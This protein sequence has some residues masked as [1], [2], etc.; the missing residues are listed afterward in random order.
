MKWN[1]FP[2]IAFG[3]LIIG[4][5]LAIKHYQKL[6]KNR[7]DKKI[8]LVSIVILFAIASVVGLGAL[9]VSFYTFGNTTQQL[10]SYGLIHPSQ[11][12]TPLSQ[13][14]Q[15][16]FP[17]ILALV[18]IGA[19]LLYW[20]VAPLIQN[21]V[22]T[23]RTF[24]EN[25][26]RFKL[27]F[28]LPTMGIALVSLDGYWMK[29][30]PALCNILGYSE[31]ELLQMDFQALTHPE[32]VKINLANRKELLEGKLSHFEM[33]ER[34]Y[35]KNE[36][37]IWVKVNV[38]LMR[39]LSGEPLYFVTQLQ[40]INKQKEAEQ[41]LA[42]Q[43]FFDKLTGLANR[44]QLEHLFGHILGTARRHSKKFAVLFLDLDKFKEV[45]DTLGHHAGDQ[46]LI[47]MA[48]RL[49]SSVRIN[50][51]VSRWGGDEFILMITDIE[52]ET[53][54][55]ITAEKIKNT[56]LHPVRIS[57]HELYLTA[58]VGISIYPTDGF[59]Y[60]ILIKN[61]DAALYRAKENGRNNYQFYSYKASENL[62]EKIEFENALQQA[63][64]K[65]EFQLH[66]QPKLDLTSNDVIGFESLL[67]WQSE[68]Y[69]IVPPKRILSLA[70]ETGLIIPLSHW[71]LKAVCLQAKKWHDAG[72]QGL[73]VSL[74]ISAQQFKQSDFIYN[75]S[76][77][78]N[79]TGL[80]SHC[81]ELEISESLAMQDP[82]YTL[83]IFSALKGLG[84]QIT[85]DN[86][87]TGYSSF[88]YLHQFAVDRIK[89]DKSI[90]QSIAENNC[91]TSLVMTMISLSKN[92][93]V[94]I[95]AQ[96][97]ETKHQYVFL[98]KHHC[99]EAQGFYFSQPLAIKKAD[100]FLEQLKIVETI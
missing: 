39:N 68:K 5:S 81:L 91:D 56:L 25:E 84:V 38:S 18:V 36:G 77:T 33:E 3:M 69:G 40:D 61:A 44:N 100:E 4:M 35:K 65:N 59:N 98:R 95:L 21:I 74:N 9:A 48:D 26:T 88:S 67:R 14:L 94:K 60:E 63:L 20:Q 45:N 8:L 10:S 22:R 42:H 70:N 82:E 66:Y 89:I 12:H 79:T 54:I 96:G 50:D 17:I 85:I 28:D 31:T 7:E 19:L 75:I 55:A 43:A 6:Y 72:H 27:A 83:Q 16:L 15:I 97:V 34:Y 93:G 92:L 62:Y 32:D 37:F 46:L 47:I 87:G 76:Q 2:A 58:S 73:N 30:N 80:N 86:F 13:S 1:L 24:Q 99:D 53:D 64:A 41:Q 29:V 52:N 78:L 57:E 71:V 49:K 11:I 23:N 90:I 51:I